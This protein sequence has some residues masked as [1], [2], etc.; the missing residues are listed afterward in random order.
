VPPLP[1]LQLALGLPKD[2]RV[3]ALALSSNGR[4]IAYTTDASGFSQIAVRSLEA[5]N[6]VLLEG[7][8][9]AHHPFFSPDGEWLGFFADGKLRKVPAHGGTVQDICDAPVDSAGGSWNADNRIVFAPLDGRGLVTVDARG[10]RPEPLT[11]INTAE[12]ELAHGW[13]HFL[14]EDDGGLVFTIARREKD[15]RIA[16]LP[17]DTSVPRQ[18]LPAHGAVQYMSGHLV[19]AFIGRLYALRF[20]AST[21]EAR[22]GPTPLADDVAVSPRGFDALGQSA[23]ATSR[24]GLIAYLPGFEQ[25]PA[26]ALVWV[27]RDGT[28]STFPSPAGVHET[29]RVSPDGTHVAMVIRSGP[30]SREVW[31][32]ELLS[33][34]RTKLTADGSQ[35]HSPVWSPDGRELAF[36]SNRTG[37]QSIFVQSV[38]AKREPRLLL[39]GQDTHIPASWSR[40]TLAFYEV[41]GSAGRDI[42]IHL[43][44]GRARPVVATPAN[45]RAP[46][47]SPDGRW[48]AY[49]SDGSGTDEIYVQSVDGGTPARVSLNGG[50]E[51]VW[52]RDGGELFYRHAEEMFAVPIVT[53]PVF[54]PGEPVRLFARDFQMDPGDNL[55]NYDV[56]PDGR[57][58]MVR[59]TDDPVDLRV[60]L[61]WQR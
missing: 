40:A 28:A 32:L 30:F 1:R 9:G 24:E 39:G 53:D 48:M 38:A 12:G 46:A 36:A 55:P 52:S 31:V 45:E 6:S 26:N 60:I 47:L 16:V 43:P 49:T 61:N 3:G 13:P 22:G 44:D 2:H 29:P 41:Y 56:A 54:Q 11:H 58:L 15:P 14:P 8:A 21:L 23:F 57:F 34:R 42:W 35:N 5:G 27:Q 50:T 20:D 7:T 4:V 17:P 37:L 19:Y 18:L 33:G 51:P 10:G 25:Q 59:R